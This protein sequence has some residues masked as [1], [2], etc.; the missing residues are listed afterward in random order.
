MYFQTVWFIEFII[1]DM[2]IFIY[3]ISILEVGGLPRELSP[4]I[5]FYTVLQLFG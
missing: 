5:Y 1:I 4:F 3:S 2:Q